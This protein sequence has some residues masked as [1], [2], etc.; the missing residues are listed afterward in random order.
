M[1]D[2]TAVQ[3]GA[4]Y[5]GS[6]SCINLQKP[7]PSSFRHFADELDFPFLTG[8]HHSVCGL[9]WQ[10]SLYLSASVARRSLPF[11]QVYVEMP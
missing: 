4:M 3:L 6:V 8:Q 1:T 2:V 10:V 5:S 11:L 7:L 9:E